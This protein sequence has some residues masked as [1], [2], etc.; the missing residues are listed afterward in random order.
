[1]ANFT[2]TQLHQ[3]GE[4]D[5]PYHYLDLKVDDY[6]Y[7]R[8][9]E[10]VSLLNRVKNLIKPFRGQKILDAGCGD[11][12]FCYEL[13]NENVDIY[14]I[15][16]SERAINFAKA[17]NSRGKFFVK[18][19]KN[20]DLPYKF[21]SVILIETL[22]HFIPSDAD[23][24]LKNL[25]E[26]LKDNGKLIVTVPSKNLQ[27]IK[28]HYQHFDEIS[29]RKILEPFFKVNFIEGYSRKG[30]K[31]KLFVL[32]RRAGFLVFPLMTKINLIKK[33]YIFLRNYYIKNLDSGKP[34]DCYGLIAICE[35]Q[36]KVI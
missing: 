8:S 10:Y 16:F 19:L 18:D 7:L 3:E 23:K 36:A 27:L 25:S 22:E 11:G 2:E 35:K 32:L 31:R 12:R 26:V 9:I 17:F 28:K 24:I 15:D 21:D 29:L 20:L 33:Y 34:S 13:R 14:G 1:M 30:F 4:Y 5:F 6:K